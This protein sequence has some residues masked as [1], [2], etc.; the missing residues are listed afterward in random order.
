L[1]TATHEAVAPVK[2][3]DSP[4]LKRVTPWTRCTKVDQH[5]MKTVGEDILPVEVKK[6]RGD[7]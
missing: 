3:E 1:K 7:R 6:R 2:I 5:R 4:P